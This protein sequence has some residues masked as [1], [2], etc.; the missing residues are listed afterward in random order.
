[1]RNGL[2]VGVSLLLVAAAGWAV[3]W[4]AYRPEGHVSDFAKVIDPAS[5]A[6]LESYAASVEQSTGVE[7]ALVTVPS[8]EGE[9]VEEVAHALAQ[10]WGVG[11][12]GRND[13]VLLLLAVQDHRSRLEVDPGLRDAVPDSLATS[14]L[15]E[16]RPA[17]RQ[18]HYGEA[19]MAAAQTIGDAA[20]AGR[21]TAAP[22]SPPRRIRPAVG[23]WFRWPILA[24][25]ILLVLWLL[26][27]GGARGYSGQSRRGSS[28]AGGFLPWLLLG[29]AL[30]RSTWGSRGSGGFGGYDSGDG[31]FGG[32]GGGDFGGGG[33]ASGDW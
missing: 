9:P 29:T 7:M 12:K 1:M 11:K 19:L 22:A 27:S 8:L 18:Q 31:G 10:G 17:L 5:R 33:G 26:R 13:G 23:D 4:A 15:A 6:Q 30:S 24:G 20:A 28:W 2:R 32:F 3:D 25:G 14:I 16:M 21:K